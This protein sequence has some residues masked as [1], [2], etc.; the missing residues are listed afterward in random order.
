[1]DHG[2]QVAE[3]RGVRGPNHSMDHGVQVAERRGV[4]GAGGS[5]LRRS[6][7]KILGSPVHWWNPDLSRL[8]SMA[9]V[10]FAPVRSGALPVLCLHC[11]AGF[12]TPSRLLHAELL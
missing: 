12:S 2:V 7:A 3:R 10:G 4:R 9:A 6:P 8:S 1:M 5:F 11:A